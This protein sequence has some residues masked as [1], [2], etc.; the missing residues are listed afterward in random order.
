MKQLLRTTALA[1]YTGGLLLSASTASAFSAGAQCDD[2]TSARNSGP[3]GSL[4]SSRLER[5]VPRRWSRAR[6]MRAAWPGHS[7]DP[8]ADRRASPRGHGRPDLYR[9]ERPERPTPSRPDRPRMERPVPP[10]WTD[11]DLHRMDPPPRPEWKTRGPGVGRYDRTRPHRY[12]GMHAPGAPFDRGF[13]E[14]VAP[15]MPYVFPYRAAPPRIAG[16]AFAPRPSPVPGTGPEVPPPP[17]PGQTPPPG[18]QATEPVAP[19]PAAVPVTDQ[20]T[21]DSQ[22]AVDTDADGVADTRDLCT[23]TPAGSAVNAFGCL[24]TETILLHGVRFHEDSARLTE[25]SAVV[26]DV[27]ATTLAAHPDLHVE[28]A[29]HADGAGDDIQNYDLS[30]RQALVVMQH[31]ADQGAPVDSMIA[32]G[33]GSNQPPPAS[34]NGGSDNAGN[35]RVELRPFKQTPTP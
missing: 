18:N 22:A 20:P 11:R 6:P 23:A 29:G 9:P 7:G 21:A 14:G 26:L 24:A 2:E 10:E 13:Y 15:R 32:R 16:P 31:L 25:D 5:P 28:I 30:T 12:R 17:A 1:L 3:F 4:S 34:A 27:I 33:Y 8:L 19:A 35:R